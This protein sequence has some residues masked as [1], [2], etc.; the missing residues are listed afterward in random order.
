MCTGVLSHAIQK[1][2]SCAGTRIQRIDEFICCT[3]VLVSSCVDPSCAQA[4]RFGVTWLQNIVISAFDARRRAQA[5]VF[6]ASD[7]L[8][9]VQGHKVVL[10]LELRRAQVHG[11]SAS[12]I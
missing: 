11:F 2:S 8:I 7:E 10:S 3:G 9:C 6:Q 1:A 4:C 12:Q 5:C